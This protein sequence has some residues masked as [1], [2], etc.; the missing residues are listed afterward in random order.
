MFSFRNIQTNLN[1]KLTIDGHRIHALVDDILKVNLS[2]SNIVEYHL[3]FLQIV[4]ISSSS[5]GWINYLNYLNSLV[6][7]GI[8]ATSLIS[9][10]N[11]FI[12]MNN[13][14]NPIISIIVQLNDCELSFQPPL[15]PLTS[16]LSLEEIL[17]NW[18]RS[19]I[20]RGDFIQL[21]GNDSTRN[22]SQMIEEDPLINELREKIHQLIEETSLESLKLF[23]AFQQYSFLY[24]LPVNQSFQLF[25]NGDKRVKSSTP[26]NFL[27][28]Q[29]AGKRLVKSLF[30]FLLSSLSESKKKRNIFFSLSML[31]RFDL[32]S[33]HFTFL[34]LP[35]L[36]LLEHK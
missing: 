20:H 5:P 18:I 23:Q 7:N 13:E 31:Y 11:M 35:P 12:S 9:M 25:L 26:K 4:G 30:L 29:E 16:Q 6:L 28:E 34:P 32:M 3:F 19:F 24:Q 8:K 2:S 22:Y 14:N 17:F 10:K 1:E 27:N 15:L 36:P 21:L 33:S